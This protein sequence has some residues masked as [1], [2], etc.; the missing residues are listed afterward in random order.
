MWA[1]G[2]FGQV[3]QMCDDHLFASLYQYIFH[4]NGDTDKQR[5][6]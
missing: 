1:G 2:D 4:P 6:E 5:D 3:Y